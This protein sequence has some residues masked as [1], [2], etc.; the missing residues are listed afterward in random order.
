MLGTRFKGKIMEITTFGPY[1]AVITEVAGSA[2]I[3][4][5]A[6]LFISP[7]DPL[8]NGFLLG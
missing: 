1:T 6:E 3:T 2:N 4:G 8:K 5:R 7:G